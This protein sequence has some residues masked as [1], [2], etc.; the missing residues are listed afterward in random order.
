MIDFLQLPKEKRK[1]QVSL[2]DALLAVAATHLATSVSTIDVVEQQPPQTP[3]TPNQPP[4]LRST[5]FDELTPLRTPSLRSPRTP[6]PFRTP[7]IARTKPVAELPGTDSVLSPTG[8]CLSTSHSI[9]RLVA[10]VS[11]SFVEIERAAS[12]GMP[13]SNHLQSPRD[14]M[15]G[16][17]VHPG[18]GGQITSMSA[19]QRSL[20]GGV[21]ARAAA[22]ASVRG[23]R[24]HLVQEADEEAIR[25]GEIGR[26]SSQYS[27]GALST[28]RS[29]SQN[30]SRAS[31]NCGEV[32]IY[33]MQS[34]YSTDTVHSN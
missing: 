27:F 19:S 23:S 13:F 6:P 1:S 11:G 12:P 14:A 21:D 30:R 17:L 22:A 34:Q 4:S 20:Y 18:A 2:K 33:M 29:Q 26:D 28:S 3:S 10:S 16:P 24:T 32:R 15:L 25:E 9:G 31:T 8:D 5:V 7:P